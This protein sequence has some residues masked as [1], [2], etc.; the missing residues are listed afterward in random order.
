MSSQVP[1]PCMLPKR[2]TGPLDTLKVVAIGP[3]A[4]ALSGTSRLDGGPEDHDRHVVVGPVAP[5]VEDGA[6]DAAGDS[7]RRPARTGRQQGLEP[8][9]AELVSLVVPGLEN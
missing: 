1:P 4:K 9:V 7:L 8:L 2:A 3:G 6:L 5:V